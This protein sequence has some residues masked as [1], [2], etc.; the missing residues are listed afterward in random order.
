[1]GVI[2]GIV[3]LGVEIQQSTAVTRSVAAQEISNTSVEFFMRIAE[4]PD[5]ARVVE[6]RLL[7]SLRIPTRL[8]RNPSTYHRC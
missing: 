6:P 1:M 5:L 3:F 2:A 7:G 8:Q 4:N